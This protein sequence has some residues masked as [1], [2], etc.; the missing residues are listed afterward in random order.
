VATLTLVCANAPELRAVFEQQLSKGRAFVPGAGGVEP[1]QACELVLEHAGRTHTLRGEAVFVKA[2]GPGAGVGVQL[3]PLDAPALQRLRDFVDAA[4]GQEPSASERQG[5]VGL[6]DRIRSLSNLEQQKLASSGTPAERIALERVYGAAVWD[7]L[8][9]NP[10][11]TTPE[12]AQIARKGTL[13]QTLVE[14]I[15]AH[16][17]WLVAPEVQRAL[18]ANPRSTPAVVDK[19]LRTIS[20]ADLRL[21][22][23]QPS[24]P[25]SV[26]AAAK[27]MLGK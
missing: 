27:R 17:S 19:V 8:L 12:V 10:R 13:P 4:A 5:A 21:V 1:L 2:D 7:A 9:L 24:Y 20:K 25:P 3:A 26:R 18:L 11:L 23:Q 22:P 14:T 16:P 15:A 6:L